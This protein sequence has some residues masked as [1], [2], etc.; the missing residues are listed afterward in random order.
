MVFPPILLQDFLQFPPTVLYVTSPLIHGPETLAA[1]L[2]S[3]WER[4]A[5]CEDQVFPDVGLGEES[6][7]TFAA[8]FGLLCLELAQSLGVMF[9]CVLDQSSLG[10]E[11]FP[12]G[13]TGEVP[14]A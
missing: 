5:V 11:V 13:R 9:L 2:T 8:S 10:H 4:E 14:A 7:I 12:T 3:D 6:F 1:P